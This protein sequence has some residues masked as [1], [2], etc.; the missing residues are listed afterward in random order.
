MNVLIVFAHPDSS[1]FNAVLK[2]ISVKTLSEMGHD[3]MV[4]DL[5]KMHFNSV[6]NSSDIITP[7]FYAEEIKT[8]M[9]KLERADLVVFN[10]PLWWFSFPAI[11]KG[12]VDR[13]FASGFAYGDGKG[14]Y[15]AGAFK[16]KKAL[17]TFTT[18]SPEDSYGENQRHGK[19]EHMLFHI[20]HGMFRFTGMEVLQPFIAFS[21]SR[22]TGEERKKYLENYSER[23]KT[24]FSEKS[25]GW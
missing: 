24:I 25:I 18:G 4:S 22:V 23:L 1:S 14:I 9:E 20:H 8:E 10:F 7:G 5:Y 13:I 17:L 19:I 21:P 11:M 3:V 2:D 6:G 16:G 12:W 15:C